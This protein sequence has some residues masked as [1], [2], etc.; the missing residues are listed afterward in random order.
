VK[1]AHLVG[2]TTKKFIVA[3]SVLHTPKKQD[4]EE[5]GKTVTDEKEAVGV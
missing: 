1:L 5:R 4:T 2:F 3:H